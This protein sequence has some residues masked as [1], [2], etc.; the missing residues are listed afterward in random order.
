MKLHWIIVKDLKSQKKVFQVLCASN[1]LVSGS[2]LCKIGGF[3]MRALLE[4][5]EL[6][7]NQSKVRQSISPSF[8]RTPPCFSF[9]LGAL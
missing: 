4:E 6:Q 1:V 9:C 3:D 8:A 7:G 2:G 5:E